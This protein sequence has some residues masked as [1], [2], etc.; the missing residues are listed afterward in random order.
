[1]EIEVQM[2]RIAH[3]FERIADSL[4]RIE[5]EGLRLDT[6]PITG[7]ISANLLGPLCIQHEFHQDVPI[8][9][10][11]VEPNQRAF[12][13]ELSNCTDTESPFAVQID[14]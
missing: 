5:A 9:L 1:M 12:K 10:I 7:D 4:E 2:S 6:D 11:H 3:A 14:D 8:G 13:V